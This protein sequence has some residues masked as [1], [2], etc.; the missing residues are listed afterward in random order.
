MLIGRD[1]DLRDHF[2]A[3]TAAVLKSTSSWLD[4][5]PVQVSCSAD[6]NLRVMRTWVRPTS[7]SRDQEKQISRLRSAIQ[8]PLIHEF[9]DAKQIAMVPIS[10]RAPDV[11]AAAMIRMIWDISVAGFLNVK[12]GLPFMK[13][14]LV[15][16][17]CNKD[18]KPFIDVLESGHYASIRNGWLFN[19]ELLLNRAKQSRYFGRR[20]FKFRQAT[21]A[22]DSMF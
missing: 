13:P 6:R 14:E 17:Y 5:F 15:R 3:K 19:T 22:I 20:R 1:L 7:S 16:I 18:L 10:C 2:Q 4:S 12:S 11:V 8:F 21:D 9:F